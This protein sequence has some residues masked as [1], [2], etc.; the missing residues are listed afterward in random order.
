MIR[1]GD[2]FVVSFEVTAGDP[3]SLAYERRFSIS[4]VRTGY[5]FVLVATVYILS[6]NR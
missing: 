2:Y 4:L 6:H 3:V 1:I 5:C